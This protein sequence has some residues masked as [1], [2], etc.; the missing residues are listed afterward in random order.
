MEE[1]RS[2]DKL[3]R[4][5]LAAVTILVAAGLFWFFRN[6]LV[7]IIL[8]FIVS[9]IG[10]PLMRLMK[11]VKIK[12]KSAPDAVLAV[13]SIIL[14]L[15]LLSFIVTEIVP[16]V[17]SIVG[18]AS[19]LDSRFAAGGLNPLEGVNDYIIATIPSVGPDF[20]LERTILDGL[21]DAISLKSVGGAMSSIIGSVASIVTTIVVGLF[22]V[23]FISFFFLKD[24]FLFDKIVASLVPD[25]LEDKI[26]KA[27]EDIKNLLSRYFVGV[28]IEMLGV[29]LLD[30]LLLWGVARLS[31]GAALGIAF[32]AGL[33]N[34]I[35]YVGPLI[36]EAIGVVL[37]VILKFG[38]GVG[39]PVSLW[40]FALIVLALML[41]TQLIDNFV[42]QPLIYST[43]IKAGPL[44][45]FIVL[46][47]AGTLGG[48]VGMLAAIPAYTVI[49]VIA[50]RFFHHLKP[51]KRLIP[52]TE[53]EV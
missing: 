51:V 32:I 5:T 18:E 50:S 7:Y 42:Y 16:V 40:A 10:L 38:A 31:V 9:L 48:V 29:A 1:E 4:Y 26:M 34:I 36:G 44:E 27:L 22:S 37:A 30:F 25:R 53:G 41:T 17:V 24:E 15:G 2:V 19:A 43:S 28:L 8:A 21:K 46:L 14:I 49:R 6:I 11:K 20:R 35:P 47:I 45:I 13:I 23:I 33:L 52:D 12:G 3:A 39:L